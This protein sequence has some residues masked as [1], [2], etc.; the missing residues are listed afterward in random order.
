MKTFV[1]A[2]VISKEHVRVIQDAVMRR[3]NIL[4][5]GGGRVEWTKQDALRIFSSVDCTQNGMAYT[6]SPQKHSEGQKET[7][8][9]SWSLQGL[10]MG[11]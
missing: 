4:V 5:A 2:E 1:L 11:P 6:A 8:P 7:V 10:S 9:Y 3:L